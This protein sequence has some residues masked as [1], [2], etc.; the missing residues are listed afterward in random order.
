MRE[1]E[2]DALEGRGIEVDGPRGVV[3][4]EHGAA[5]RMVPHGVALPAERGQDEQACRAAPVR[6]LSLFQQSVGL[7]GR[8]AVQ[9]R[10]AGPRGGRSGGEDGGDAQL[11]AAESEAV[12]GIGHPG[13][14]VRHD[15]DSRDPAARAQR[16]VVAS[17]RGAG[18]ADRR[19]AR[20][21]GREHDRD[22]GRDT[23]QIAGALA[24]AADH[25]ADPARE[26][27]QK[28]RVDAG[29][30]GDGGRPVASAGIEHARRRGGGRI[31]PGAGAE[32]MREV[33][34]GTEGDAAGT[35][36]GLRFDERE[37]AEHGSAAARVLL[38]AG[39]HVPVLAITGDG[40]ADLAGLGACAEVGVEDRGA[41]RA[42]IAA[43]RALE[44][45][46]LHLAGEAE[47]RD[48]GR[49]RVHLRDRGAGGADPAL[50][51]LL[52]AAVG[53]RGGGIW[54]ARGGETAA[55]EVDQRRLRGGRAEVEAEQR[56][57]GDRVGGARARCCSS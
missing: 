6:A 53:Q 56:G 10:F 2:S 52:G 27:R 36:D 4:A 35:A 26:A 11:E 41:H 44:D 24:R 21:A 18:D 20:V 7:G 12:R 16:R 57:H 25:L 31:A 29:R 48:V 43:R 49:S 50:G 3:E 40:L 28:G 33:A 8:G 38:G 37:A 51:I 14:L 15:A 46:V 34:G 47:R 1:S 9:V 17:G 45:Q 39:E 32:A 5:Q 23:E 13:A 55:L 30:A 42:V 54:L 22:A 19:G